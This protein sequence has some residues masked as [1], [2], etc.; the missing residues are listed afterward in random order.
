MAERV[1]GGCKCGHVRYEGIR[2]SAATFRCHCRDCQKLTGSGHSEMLPL[3]IDT[4]SISETCKVF[5]MQGGSGQ[6]TYSG[7]CPNC[8]S[9]DAGEFTYLSDAT[10]VRP[11]EDVTDV[12]EWSDHVFLRK[13][14]RGDHLE[15]WHHSGGCR[16]ILKVK[17]NS[18]THLIDGVSLEGAWT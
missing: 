17:R 16:G 6:P 12:A 10:T 3:E 14:P 18:L 13:N 4:F 9:R 5:E 7:F 2:H 11:A 8:G 1:V 15:H